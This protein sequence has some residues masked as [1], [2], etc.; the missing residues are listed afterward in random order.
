MMASLDDR[1]LGQ[2]VSQCMKKLT[3]RSAD[4]PRYAV[5]RVLTCSFIQL[6][7]DVWHTVAHLHH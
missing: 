6:V 1:W 7:I 2:H 3:K 4:A 5:Q